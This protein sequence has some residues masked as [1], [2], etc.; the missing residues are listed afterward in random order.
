MQVALTGTP[1]VG[2]TTVAETLT[3]HGH[4]PIHELQTETVTAGYAVGVDP[5][6]ETVIAD[7][8]RLRGWAAGRDGLVVSH[9]AHHLRPDR[10]IVLRCHP[11]ELE[12][13]LS[14]EGRSPAAVAENCEAEALD[15][16][17]SE[18][19]TALGPSAVAEID[20]TGRTPAAVAG[21]VK[22]LMTGPWRPSAGTVDFSGVL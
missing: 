20:T 10:A 22:A 12:H 1:G 18:A 15:L 13:R 21:E 4:I 17:L 3:P 2:K 16:I 19:V 8:S 7:I 5:D 6:R 11:L 9:L 14:A